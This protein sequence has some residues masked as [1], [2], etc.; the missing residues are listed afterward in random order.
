MRVQS[1]LCRELA[2][3]LS[4]GGFSAESGNVKSR[5]RVKVKDMANMSRRMLK[6]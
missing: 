5:D 2:H 4:P 6:C 1:H 3:D